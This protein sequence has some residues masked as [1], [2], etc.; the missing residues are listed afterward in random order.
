M[1]IVNRREGELERNKEGGYGDS[2]GIDGFN[3]PLSIL[4]SMAPLLPSQSLCFTHC[5]LQASK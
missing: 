1:R 2:S 3:G 4:V 5:Y